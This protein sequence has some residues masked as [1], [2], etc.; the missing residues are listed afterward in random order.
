MSMIGSFLLLSDEHLHQLLADPEQ[1][2]AACEKGYNAGIDVF[3]GVDKAWHCLHFLLTGTA[4]G[5][6]PPLNFV[7]TGGR[8][9]GEEDVGYGPARAFL[10]RDVIQ[11]ARA[12]EPLNRQDLVARFDAGMMD[13]LEIYPDVGRWAELARRPDVSFDYFFGAFDA[14]KSLVLRGASS[15]LGMLV[16]LS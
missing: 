10:S 8:A 4:F 9:V 5:G 2:H 15:G 6:D 3:I 16:W 7:L 12:L 13:R 1:V 11:I 14:V